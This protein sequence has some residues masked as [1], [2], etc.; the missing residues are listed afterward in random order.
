MLRQALA[1]PIAAAIF[2]SSSSVTHL[3][4]AARQAGIAFPFAGI[5]AIS[6]GPV[7]TRTLGDLGWAPAAEAGPSDVPGLIA[8]VLRTLSP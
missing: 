8:A 1:Q 6:I 7:T 5:P 2:T 3:A 4:E